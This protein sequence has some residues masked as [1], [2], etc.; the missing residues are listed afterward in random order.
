MRI[1]RFRPWVNSYELPP[2]YKPKRMVEKLCEVCG[3][4]FLATKTS[5]KYQ[6]RYCSIEHAENPNKVKHLDRRLKPLGLEPISMNESEEMLFWQ[7]VEVLKVN[8][9]KKIW[10]RKPGKGAYRKIMQDIEE[11]KKRNVFKPSF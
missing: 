7:L 4:I 2:G 3:A 8:Y 1:F 6:R 9:Y 11:L 5:K 10:G